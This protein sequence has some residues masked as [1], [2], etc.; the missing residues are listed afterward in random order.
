MDRRSE[1][2]SI[3]PSPGS[4]LQLSEIMKW[5]TMVNRRCRYVQD[6]EEDG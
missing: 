6:E 5:S 1:G 2:R 3:H 4:V